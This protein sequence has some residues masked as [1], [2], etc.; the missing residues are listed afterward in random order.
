MPASPL[1]L[2]AAQKAALEVLR[3]HARANPIDV[4][5]VRER[6]KTPA[7]HAAHIERMQMFTVSI[8]TAFVVTYSVETGHP[9]G[10]CRHLS[11]SSTRHGRTPTPE[12]VWMLAQALG[13]Q[14]DL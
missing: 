7:G 4:L 6:V 10:T 13:F 2:G 1:I 5:A 9:C 14:G 8:P 3:L 12:A 11:M